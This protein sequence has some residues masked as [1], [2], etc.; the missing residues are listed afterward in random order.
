MKIRRGVSRAGAAACSTSGPNDGPTVETRP[1]RRRKAR[2]PFVL[3]VHYRT[4]ADSPKLTGEGQ[5]INVSRCG[6]LIASQHAVPVGAQVEVTIE[7]P[8]Y[9]GGTIP[10]KL[11]TSGRVTR[12]DPSSFVMLFRRYE[13][14]TTKRKPASGSDAGEALEMSQSAGA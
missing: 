8:V 1:E 4:V 10:L 9:L 14:R 5:T 6:L 11:V 7:W 2:F 3:N 13:F 12:S